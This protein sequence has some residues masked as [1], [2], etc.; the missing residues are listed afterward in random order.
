MT[1][2]DFEFMARLR[3]YLMKDLA[4]ATDEE[5]RKEAE[6]DGSDLERRKE[7]HVVRYRAK[8]LYTSR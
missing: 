7:D 5:L 6:E 1:S 3:Q 4:A 8:R 2:S